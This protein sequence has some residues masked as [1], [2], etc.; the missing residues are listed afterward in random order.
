MNI[1]LIEKSA[2]IP[3]TSLAEEIKK[4]WLHSKAI[5]D[6]DVVVAGISMENGNWFVNLVVKKKGSKIIG[7]NNILG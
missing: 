5:T 1:Q 4:Q 6:D 7:V 2:R 3:L